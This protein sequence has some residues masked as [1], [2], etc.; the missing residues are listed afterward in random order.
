MAGCIC[1]ITSQG[2]LQHHVGHPLQ[3]GLRHVQVGDWMSMR[4]MAETFAKSVTSNS[5]WMGA[6]VGASVS[7]LSVDAYLPVPHDHSER[8]RLRSTM[9]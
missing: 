4:L 7:A 6:A 1:F 9:K 5:I 3:D 8:Y 2:T